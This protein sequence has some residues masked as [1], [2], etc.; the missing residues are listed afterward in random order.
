MCTLYYIEHTND[1]IYFY[2][3]NPKSISFEM[4]RR[5]THNTAF[6]HKMRSAHKWIQWIYNYIGETIYSASAIPIF[7][8]VSK[9]ISNIFV[10]SNCCIARLIYFFH[11][12]LIC[13]LYY[14]VS[15]LCKCSIIERKLMSF[16]L[17]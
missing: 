3:R 2:G 5:E 16:F 8:H 10:I 7:D 14:L 4:K 12:L 17:F 15:N 1:V 11:F 13:L 6:I 9:Y